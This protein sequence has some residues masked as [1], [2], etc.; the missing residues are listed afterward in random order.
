MRIECS[1]IGSP[2]PT[3]I[4]SK[5]KQQ[6]RAYKRDVGNKKRRDIMPQKE[7]KSAYNL[8]G[9]IEICKFLNSMKPDGHRF[10]WME[11]IFS[12]MFTKLST[13]TIGRQT[14]SMTNCL[15]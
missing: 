7:G 1:K 10:P 8:T 12:Q 14:M 13:S 2:W 4:D 15:V 11:G 9:Y 6:V 3:E 5:L